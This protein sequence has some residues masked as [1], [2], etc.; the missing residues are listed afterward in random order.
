[1]PGACGMKLRGRH[2][3]L[4]R[5]GA[6]FAEEDGPRNAH[7]QRPRRSCSSSVERVSGPE[8]PA[9]ASAR[10]HEPVDIAPPSAH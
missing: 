10:T 7:L 5:D 3:H 6:L 1:M 9:S 8:N 4:G 2:E